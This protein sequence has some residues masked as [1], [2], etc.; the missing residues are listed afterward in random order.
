MSAE[1]KDKCHFDGDPLFNIKKEELKVRKDR[2]E[3]N[4][5]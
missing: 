5:R 1:E 3:G 4:V 2:K